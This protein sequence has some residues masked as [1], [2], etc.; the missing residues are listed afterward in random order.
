MVVGCDV[1]NK[2][3]VGCRFILPAV[4]GLHFRGDELGGVKETFVVGNFWIRLFDA[5]FTILT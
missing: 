1:S 2:H 4:L 3:M 5:R